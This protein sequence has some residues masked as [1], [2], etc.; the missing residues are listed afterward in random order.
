MKYRQALA[1]A[2]LV[3]SACAGRQQSD[4][5][6]IKLDS[7]LVQDIMATSDKPMVDTPRRKDFYYIEHYLNKSDSTVSRILKDSLGHIV[8]INQTRKG[9]R[10][11]VAEY[12]PNGQIKGKLTIDGKGNF[13]VPVT[14]YYQDGRIRSVGNFGDMV[15][16]GIWKDYD[17]NGYLTQLR[18]EK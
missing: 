3:L 2:T 7:G 9:I 11:F 16:V 14:Y 10:L 18:Q 13:N 5:E 1:V 6:I 4:I 12:Y 8:G 17:S 15:P